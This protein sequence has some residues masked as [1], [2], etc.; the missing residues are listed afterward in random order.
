LYQRE[1]GT[2]EHPRNAGDLALIG[3]GVSAHPF[4]IA[5]VH[6]VHLARADMFAVRPG[7][8]Q[9]PSDRLEAVA[10]QLSRCEIIAEYGIH[11]VNQFAS[12]RDIPHASIF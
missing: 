7:N 1:C 2:A 6:G 9:V 8:P 10:R 11:R 5:P 4:G 12:G 3:C